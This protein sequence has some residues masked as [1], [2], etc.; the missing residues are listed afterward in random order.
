LGGGGAA[1]GFEA[2]G[3]LGGGCDRGVWVEVGA[4]GAVWV[5]IDDTG[6]HGSGAVWLD[7]PE[8]VVLIGG[9]VGEAIEVE[10][11]ALFAGVPHDGGEDAGIGIG[12]RL[13]GGDLEF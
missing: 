1:F 9:G 6:V 13:E 8:L 12:L 2:E 5:E 10:D 4:G 11:A 3:E 7:D